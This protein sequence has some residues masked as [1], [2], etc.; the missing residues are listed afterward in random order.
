MKLTSRYL[1]SKTQKQS[2]LIAVVI[3]VLA[4]ILPLVNVVSQIY[5]TLFH[6]F[7]HAVT[8]WLFG[9]VAIPRL[10][11]V[12]GGGVTHLIS[13]PFLLGVLAIGFVGLNILLLKKHKDSNSNKLY[14]FLL[15]AYLLIFFT[16]I[17]R[18][19]IN[20]MGKAG[21]LLFF[22]FVG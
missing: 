5:S 1:L 15:V 12:N 13:R 3:S 14:L 18:L 17:N 11:L 7:G 2:L 10:D 9:Y 16:T 20:F 6:E 19:L 8:A 22:Y 21:V 4:Q